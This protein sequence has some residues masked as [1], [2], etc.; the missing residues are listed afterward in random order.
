MTERVG[1]TWKI[2]NLFFKLVEV[3]S[4]SYHWPEDSKMGTLP[5]NNM[6]Q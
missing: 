4:P 5:I 6:D 2:N 1:N 3:F